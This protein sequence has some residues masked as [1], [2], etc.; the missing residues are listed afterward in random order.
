M[1]RSRTLLLGAMLAAASLPLSAFAKDDDHDHDNDRDLK[2][3]NLNPAKLRRSDP[4]AFAAMIAAR[5]RLF[6]PENVDPRNGKV[7]EKKVIVSWFS[8]A[9]LAVAA[10]GRVFLLDSY[11]YRL[12]DNRN[13]YVPLVRQDLVDVQPEAIFLGHGHGDHADN[14]AYIAKL[15]GATIYGAAEHCAAMQGDAARIFGAGTTVNC[16][17]ITPTGEAPGV[18]RTL[19]AMN[20]D[21]CIS[22]FKH[23][24]SGAA[25]GA[26]PTTNPINPVRDPRVDS[27]YPPQPAPTPDTRTQAL[28]GGAVS[29]MY[30]FTVG[31][32]DFTFTW[33]NTAGPIRELAPQIQPLLSSLPKT[34]VEFG[35][36]VS[37]GETVTGV[38]DIAEYI[39][40]LQPKVFYMFHSD[41]FNIGASMYYVK[42]IQREFNQV[43]PPLPAALRPEIRGFH[44]P[45]DYVRPGLATFDWKD[46]YW[47]GSQVPNRASARCPG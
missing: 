41:N 26:S 11:I 8:V 23:Q 31:G 30:Q 27:L 39:S 6:G 45:Y 46:D 35:S 13:G 1:K 19:H 17:T 24:H 28:N 20:P 36:G 43:T 44:D 3:Q 15:T 42:A 9:S 4:E 14:A 16:V 32:S 7:D 18:L 38:R 22:A 2:P 40:R 21:L 12:A 47:R 10:K 5:K 37:I 33:H 29:I 34:D 25:P